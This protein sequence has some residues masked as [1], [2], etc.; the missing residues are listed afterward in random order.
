[1]K[2]CLK[3]ERKKISQTVSQSMMNNRGAQKNETR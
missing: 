1:M 2:N 3:N